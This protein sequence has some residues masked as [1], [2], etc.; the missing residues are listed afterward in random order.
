MSNRE[1]V[2]FSSLAS[3][4]PIAYAA[5]CALDTCGMDPAGFYEESDL[6]FY[7]HEGVLFS[8]SHDEALLHAWTGS[9]WEER[10]FSSR[11]L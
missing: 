3:S 9:D 6:S 11:P 5:L 7:L 2:S 10:D 1:Y 4:H 8:E